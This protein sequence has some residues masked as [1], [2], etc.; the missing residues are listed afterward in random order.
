MMFFQ[1]MMYAVWWVPLAAYLT[2]L[3]VGANQKA[4]ILSSM[5]IGCMVS[6]LIGMLADRFFAAQKVLATLNFVNAAML[7]L[8]GTTNNPKML[9]LYLLLTMMAYMP[10]WSL[11]SSIAM[12]HIPSVDFPKI[13]VFGS[14]GWVASGIFG[15]I[16]MQFLNIDFDGTNI[17][18]YCGSGVSLFAAFANLTLPDTPPLANNKSWKLI[19]A[20]GLGS[21]Q[22]IKERNFLVFII[23]SFLSM[24][25]FAMYYSY[26][27]EFLLSINIKYISITINWGI[28]AEMGFLLLVPISIKKLGLRKTMLIG[29]MTLTFRYLTFYFGGVVDQPWLYYIGILVHGLIFGFFYV[30]G[31]IYID[32]KAPKQLKSQAQGFIFLITFG[33]GLLVGNFLSARLIEYFKVQDEYNWDAVWKITALFT[34]GLLIGFIF[35]FKKIDQERKGPY[36]RI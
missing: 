12:V 28:L 5:A 27:S 25:P 2:N 18:F 10:S 23:F 17:P 29:L 3:E 31:Q 35:L 30:G 13:R 36:N 34:L 15:F 9:F 6:P 4:L 1:Y 7:F 32:D 26:F 8:A 16:F 22:L 21:I 11:T 33:V 14:I 20:F 19:D 24:I